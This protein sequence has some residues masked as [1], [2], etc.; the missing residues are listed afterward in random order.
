VLAAL[1]PPARAWLDQVAASLKELPRSEIQIVSDA[2]AK[3]NDTNARTLALE[4]AARPGANAAPTGRL[5]HKR[6]SVVCE[7]TAPPCRLLR[8]C[9]A[10]AAS[11]SDQV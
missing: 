7:T 3:G 1:Q 11:L 4:R 10:E 9:W 5:T 8:K 6:W 2:D